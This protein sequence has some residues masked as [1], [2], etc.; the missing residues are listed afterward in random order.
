VSAPRGCPGMIFPKVG[1]IQDRVFV[2]GKPFQPSLMFVG[3]ARPGVYPRVKH[4]PGARVIKLIT[5]V[6]YLDPTVKP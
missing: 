1:G 2:P 5:A 6:I 3:E 4:L